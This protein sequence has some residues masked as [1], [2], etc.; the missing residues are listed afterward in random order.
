MT[1]EEALKICRLA[2]GAV[3]VK[4]DSNI[5][6]NK[7]ESVIEGISKLISESADLYFMMNAIEKQIPKKIAYDENG[8]EKCPSCGGGVDCVMYDYLYGYHYC[9]DCG[10][11][12]DWRKDDE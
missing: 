12:L 8:Y 3:A 4:Q 5:D 6:A 11:R 2:M 7:V 9:T 10:Q 1:N